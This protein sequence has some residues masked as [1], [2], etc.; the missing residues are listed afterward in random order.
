[1]QKDALEGLLS[2]K[3]MSLLAEITDYFKTKGIALVEEVERRETASQV[4]FR[5]VLLQKKWFGRSTVYFSITISLRNKNNDWRVE[6]DI[7]WSAAKEH[8]PAIAA[9]LEGAR[10]QMKKALAVDLAGAAYVK[11]M[12]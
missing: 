1:M 7:I 10:G 4:S 6:D 9:I 2:Q 3:V 12:A 11:P 5:F 8:Q